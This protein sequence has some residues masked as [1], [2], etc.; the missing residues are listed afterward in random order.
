MQRELGRL[1]DHPAGEQ[2]RDHGQPTGIPGSGRVGDHGERRADLKGTEGQAVHDDPDEEERVAEP[3]GQEGL[4]RSRAGLGQLAVVAD[5]GVRAQAHDLPADEQ[6]HEVV[7][8]DH[9]QHGRGEQRDER[10]V[11]RVARVAAE[12]LDRVDLDQQR[13]HGH[14]HR[15]DG[16]E[17][18]QPGR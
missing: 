11:R 10:C 18:V 14:H 5:E 3:G 4:E 6:D 1:P 2:Q 13:D 7:G 16:C 8:D 12:V 17:P 9:Q 15:D